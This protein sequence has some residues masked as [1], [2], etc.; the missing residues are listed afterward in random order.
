MFLITGA[1]GNLGSATIDY[2]L[3]NDPDAD[4]AGL[5]RSEGKGADLKEKGVEL[6]IG[7]YNDYDSIQKAVQGIDVLLLISSS[8][9]E[10]R[11]KQH[12]NVIN[13]AKGAGVQQLFYTS[14]VQADKRLS[15]L[16]PDHHETE[17]LIK[18]SDIPY[19]IFRHTFYT[20]F[21]P[22]YWEGALETGKWT[23]PSNG[24]KLNFALRTEMAEAL[25]SA[26]SDPSK[27]R[28]S[29]YEITSAKAYTLGELAETL[30][31]AAGKNIKYNDLPVE[32]FR[33]QLEEAGVPDEIRML[34][35]SVAETFVNGGLD[36]TDD[37]LENLLG[38]KPLDTREFIRQSVNG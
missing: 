19:T 17:K 24:K 12:E 23:F 36:Y 13:A 31:E 10:G 28:N 15:P 29:V 22:M 5:V 7:D 33:K 35:I 11:V 18:S 38:R 6:R 3:K 8:S 4:V 32:A 37:A 34:T 2:M 20:E 9:L 16:A 26:L 14:I 1:N 27:H 25:A 30:G 21:L